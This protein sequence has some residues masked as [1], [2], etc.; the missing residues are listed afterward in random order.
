MTILG[1]SDPYVLAAYAGCFLSTI[2]C[3]IY[4]LLKKDKGEE[5]DE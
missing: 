2:V 3:I 5:E 4:G 1:L